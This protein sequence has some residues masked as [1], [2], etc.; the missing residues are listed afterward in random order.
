MDHSFCFPGRVLTLAV[1]WMLMGW[2]TTGPARAEGPSTARLPNVVIMFT[3]D[4]GYQDVGCFGRRTSRRRTSTA[5]RAEGMRFTDFYAAQAVCSASRAAMMTG[6]YSNRVG[7]LGALGPGAKIGIHDDEMTLARVGQAARLRHGRLSA[8]GTW[9]TTRSSCPRGTGSTNTSACPTRTTCGRIIRTA[10]NFPPL[11]LIEGEKIVDPNVTADDQTQL[12]TWYTERAVKFIEKNQERPFF[13]YVAHSMPHVPL[14]VSEKFKGKSQ[15]GLYGD[16]IMEIDWS[17]GQILETLD[18]LGL[19]DNTLVIFTSD[20]GPWLSYGEHAG[21][22]LPLREGKGRCST[23]AA[24]CR[25]S[26]GGRADSRGQR[27]PRGGRPRST[28]CRRSPRSD[29]CRV[30]Q[31]PRDR[32]PQHPAADEGRA[33]GEEPAR[34]ALFLLGQRV[35]GGPQR[36]VEAAFPARLPHAGRP[37]WPSAER[38]RSTRRPRSA[39]NCSTW[40]ATSARRPTWPTRIPRW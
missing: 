8:S 4:Q 10:K 39:W 30:A 37:P 28:C 24:A 21:C 14:F 19:D 32:R 20:N 2:Q 35:A 40:K 31:G 18:R 9:A 33:R 25:A 27:L 22:A 17:V 16:V 3:D 15:R 13:L 6:C 29:R 1:C 7:I 26:C 36:Q 38:R 12:T 23:A 11:P 34:G 5:W